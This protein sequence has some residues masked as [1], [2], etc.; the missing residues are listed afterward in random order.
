MAITGWIIG[1]WITTHDPF[2]MMSGALSGIISTASGLDIY[3]PALA[4]IIAFSA[5]ALLK[6]IAVWFDKRGIDD[7]VG[8]VA[9]HSVI[10]VYGVI[11]LGVWGSGCPALQG[12][13][14][15]VPTISLT[16]QI[17]A[18][19]VFFLLGFVPGYVVSYILKVAGMLRVR[20]G[21]ELAGMDM[22]KGPGE[23]YPEW[24]AKATPAE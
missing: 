14:G 11:M 5:G 16:G 7:A 3:F 24:G 4:F 20:P 22:V 15:D 1:V 23:S 13:A 21:A 12:A 10:G 19:V 6:S 9:L 18:A 17:V 8:A 2:W